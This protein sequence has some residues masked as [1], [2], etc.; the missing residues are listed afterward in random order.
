MHND[1][2]LSFSPSDIAISSIILALHTYT[3]GD[4]V[5]LE[6][7]KQLTRI[8]SCKDEEDKLNDAKAISIRQNCVN[9]LYKLHKFAAEDKQQQAAFTKYSTEKFLSVAIVELADEV[10]LV[11]H[12]FY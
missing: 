5:N 2:F 7:F 10:P 11:E 6:E 8:H 9:A 1:P 12:Y 4:I 3:L